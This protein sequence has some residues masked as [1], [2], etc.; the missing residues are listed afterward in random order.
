MLEFDMGG[1]VARATI[2]F[3]C[4]LLLFVCGSVSS[5]HAQLSP[6][7][8][9]ATS[10]PLGALDP[11]GREAGA[12]TADGSAAAEDGAQAQ[13]EA[14]QPSYPDCDPGDWFVRLSHETQAA[15]DH[16]RSLSQSLTSFMES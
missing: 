5:A 15:T 9:S 3:L 11:A 8:K 12:A 1:A 10:S 13:A 16:A 4:G 6:E 2:A 14:A 7:G